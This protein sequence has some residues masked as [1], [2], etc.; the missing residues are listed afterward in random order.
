MGR[1][2]WLKFLRAARLFFLVLLVTV[3]PYRAGAQVAVIPNTIRVGLAQDVQVQDFYVQGRYRLVD[4]Q[5]GE[6]LADVL[7]GE[8][9]QARFTGGGIQL[10]KNGRQVGTYGSSLD[11][12][13]VRPMVAVLSG[14]GALKN[15]AAG[16]TLAVAAAGGRV[17][18][19]KIDSGRINVISVSGIK[20]VQGGGDLNLVALVIDGRA[21]NYRGNLEFRT[22]TGGITVINELPL[23]EYLY[24]VVPRE[25][26]A[27]WPKEALKAQAVAARSYALANLGTYRDFGFDLLATQMNQVYGGYNAEHANASRAVDETRGQVLSCRGKTISAFFHSSSGGYIESCRD[28]WREDL[29]YLKAKPDPFDKNDKYYDWVEVYTRDQLVNRLIER[30]SLYN[31]PDAPERVFTIVN[32]IEIAE[33]TSSGA[34]VKRIRITGAGSDGQP[35]AAEIS[36]ADA[37]RKALGLK[38]SLFEMTKEKNAGGKLVKVTFKGS[39]YG[40]GLGMSQYGALGMT[41]KGYNYQDILKYYYNNTEVRHLS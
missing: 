27:S 15:V 8:R 14:S 5:S 19:L 33:K 7:P 21:Q 36:N 31:G 32:D 38:S 24:G 23:E 2:R 9:W 26:P 11:L 16:E 3:L 13:Q 20:A 17:L 1:E 34:R 18:P 6:H 39:G 41:N 22:R 35:M 10:F 40:H 25:M 29:E 28:V 30:K 4:R 12:Q 37:V